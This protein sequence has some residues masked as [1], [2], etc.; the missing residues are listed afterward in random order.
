VNKVVRSSAS[1]HPIRLLRLFDQNDIRV[2]AIEEKHLVRPSRM[3]EFFGFHR[4][5]NKLNLTF[6]QAFFYG[7]ASFFLAGFLKLV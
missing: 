5:Q 6:T 1:V 7:A 4:R 3:N 2:C